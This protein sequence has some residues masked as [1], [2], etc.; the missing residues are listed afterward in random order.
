MIFERGNN[1]R[2]SSDC[3]A[4]IVPPLL[5]W[6]AYSLNLRVLKGELLNER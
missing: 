2:V 4:K 6:P 5:K 3:G 1:I